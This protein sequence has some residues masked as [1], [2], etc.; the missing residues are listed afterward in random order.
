M[1]YSLHYIV[2]SVIALLVAGC[3][4]QHIEAT[5]EALLRPE[6]GQVWQLVEQRGR[7]VKRGTEVT[8]IIN[9]ESG[10]L[11]G[12]AYCNSYYAE[13][14]LRAEG[15]HYSMK[16]TTMSSGTTRCPDAEMNAQTRYLSL[17]QNADMMTLTEYTLTLYSKGKVILKY[18]LQ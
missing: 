2:L 4:V 17:L 18:E 3:A 6:K 12:T 1:K 14:I 10:S 8:L 15:N 9:T 7:E 16:I 5:G 11:R 13:Y